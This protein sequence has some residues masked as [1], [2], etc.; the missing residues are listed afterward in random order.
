MGCLCKTF[1]ILHLLVDFI[2]IDN[3][4]IH[5]DIQKNHSTFRGT[6]VKR[7]ALLFS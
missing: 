5:F 3:I 1:H 6:N 4:I 7:D 2:I